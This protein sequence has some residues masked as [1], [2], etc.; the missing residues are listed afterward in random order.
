ML[1]VDCVSTFRAAERSEGQRHLHTTYQDIKGT[2]QREPGFTIPYNLEHGR[3]TAANPARPN[4]A[5]R[6]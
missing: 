5:D 3:R 6:R 2:G 4:E 1:Q